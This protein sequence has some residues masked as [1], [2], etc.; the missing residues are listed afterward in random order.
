MA[1]IKTKFK[2]GKKLSPSELA[3]YKTL[4]EATK[5]EFATLKE[6]GALAKKVDEELA[7]YKSAFPD[8]LEAKL[9]DYDALGLAPAELQAAVGKLQSN[10]DKL[11]AIEVAKDKA[12][13][14]VSAEK[15]AGAKIDAYITGAEKEGALLTL[16]KIAAAIKG[17]AKTGT[18]QKTY[19]AALDEA[20]EVEVA[21]LKALDV[22]AAGKLAEYKLA[23]EG[24]GMLTQKKVLT[25]LESDPS[26]QALGV[27]QK[28]AKVDEVTA[29]TKAKASFN[30]IKSTVST[31]LATNQSLTASQAKWVNQLDEDG[32]E[33]LQAAVVKKQKNL[34][35]GPAVDKAPPATADNKPQL[36]FSDF[37]QVGE[38]GGSNL[39]GFFTNQRTGTKYYI[40]APENELAARVEVLSAKLYQ[41]AGVRTA[42]VDLIPITGQIGGTNAAG[43]LGIASRIETV[44]DLNPSNMSNLSGAKDG[45]AA[46]AWLANWD[47]I[48]NGA[49]RELN[50]KQLADGTAMRIDTGGSLFF[51]AQGGRKAFDA[52]DVPELDSLRDRRVNAN[53]ADVFGDINEDQIVSGVARIVSVSDDDIRRVVA[54][55]MGDA[56]DDLADVLI[57]R[58]N[59]LAAK[60]KKQLDEI[61]K[62][63]KPVDVDSAQVARSEAKIIEQSNKTGYTLSFDKDSIE[64]QALHFW[65]YQKGKK[66]GFGVNFKVR[67]AA[68]RS[69]MSEYRK[70]SDVAEDVRSE[71]DTDLLDESIVLAVRG[72]ASRASKSAFFEQKD[73]DRAIEALK[74][75]RD[76]VD[77]LALLFKAGRASQKT[78]DDFAAHYKP[79]IDDLKET[80]KTSG[81]L[82]EA[83][84]KPHTTKLFKG[85]GTFA[86]IEPKLVAGQWRKITKKFKQADLDEGVIS[87]TAKNYD[88]RTWTPAMQYKDK[89]IEVDYVPDTSELFALRDMVD[90]RILGDKLDDLNKGLKRLETLGFDLS[91]PGIAQ[92]EL[93]YLTKFIYMKAA[94]NKKVMDVLKKEFATDDEKL[95]FL[96]E[97]ASKLQGVKDITKL[98]AYRPDGNWE[99]AGY[100]RHLQNRPDLYGPDW[101]DFKSNHV[102]YHDLTYGGG[103]FVDKVRNIMRGGGH[104]APT[105][106]KL[107]RGLP[108]DGASARSDIETGGANYFFTRIKEN[109]FMRGRDGVFFKADA[110]RRLDSISYDSDYYGRMRYDAGD[111]PSGS[112]RSD[113][114]LDERY[115]SLDQFKSLARDY[116]SNETVFKNSLSMI[117]EGVAFIQVNDTDKYEELLKVVTDEL[118]SM[119]FTKWPDGREITDVVRL[120]TRYVA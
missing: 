42:D 35:I 5:E 54:D 112:V 90:V 39:G 29:Q 73:Y 27:T 48:G 37:D 100:G 68:S 41:M 55:T 87:Y 118:K 115:T 111:A 92:Q 110:L 116:G 23:E 65:N 20:A 15:V 97:Q 17:K 50:L 102:L 9:K 38:Q 120:A 81:D 77:D 91:R 67:G 66:A 57:G 7:T 26:W 119:G 6:A 32:E 94:K 79:W 101:E 18:S 21:K 117:D 36:V 28:L 22:E 52:D 71:F 30:S 107:R 75:Y 34:G 44:T 58:K 4:D 113:F 76:A 93:L 25:E 46:D 74:N 83:I 98:P 51:R 13:S 99:K 95:I 80:A 64:E 12:A 62:P 24:S 40:K 114:V 105:T 2:D 59:F 85:L 3:V 78:L 109:S 96:R 103:E 88:E 1:K 8:D 33:L 84:W 31:K 70:L 45:F 14:I 61:N 72:I 69:L 63:A 106:D 56:A 108:L 60:Y 19:L 86:L 82:A 53:G 16:D 43:R 89:F 49:A 104:M 11:A 47:V 10:A